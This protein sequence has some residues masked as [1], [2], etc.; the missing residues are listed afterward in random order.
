MATEAGRTEPNNRLVTEQLVPKTT[1]AQ[2]LAGGAERS[3]TK[4]IT[5]QRSTITDTK[6][7]TATEQPV[8][9][10]RGS[11][12]TRK[13]TVTTSASDTK[14]ATT[15]TPGAIVPT[16]SSATNTPIAVESKTTSPSPSKL[17]R[18]FPSPPR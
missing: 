12:Q 14:L 5:H 15:Y 17:S 8:V 9:R 2:K 13:M 1:A 16:K 11:V 6:P 7:S 4:E 10:G 18:S 3:V